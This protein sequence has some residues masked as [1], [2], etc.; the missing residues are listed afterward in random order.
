[1]RYDLYRNMSQPDPLP[2]TGK[3][4]TLRRLKLEDLEYFQAYRHDL[5]VGRY[6]GWSPQPENAAARFLE[7]MNRVDLFEPKTWC[8][9]GVADR[10]SDQLIG[11]IGVCLSESGDEAEIGFTLCT[12]S[13]GAGLG[14]E[15]VSLCIQLLFEQTTIARIVAITDAR[16]TPSIR[17]LER[18]R[19]QRI[20]IV[21]TLFQGS[22]CLE[23]V[24]SFSPEFDATNET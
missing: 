16:N 13:Q 17:L 20:K 24:Y 11:D 18:L 12:E 23:Y 7:T 21:D 8:Q 4:I 15:A 19:M 5:N 1:M 9:I 14:Y 2:R 22:P 10:R 3:R 6:Q